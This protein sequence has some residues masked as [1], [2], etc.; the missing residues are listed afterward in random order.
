M[1]DWPAVSLAILD[2]GACLIPAIWGFCPYWGRMSQPFAE[3]SLTCLSS[4]HVCCFFVSFLFSL[5]F[6]LAHFSC[7]PFFSCVRRS[8]V[9]R[10]FVR[11]SAV[12]ASAP[13]RCLYLFSPGVLPTRHLGRDILLCLCHRCKLRFHCRPLKENLRVRR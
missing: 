2:I 11:R 4:R 12:I 10:S 6:L 3:L 1:T 7:R 8:C 9:R 13:S 5:S